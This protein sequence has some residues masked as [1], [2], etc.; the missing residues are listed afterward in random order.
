MRTKIPAKKSAATTA[1]SEA[2]KASASAKPVKAG[3][4]DP[5]SNANNERLRELVDALSI[6]QE[7][8][9]KRFNV[10]YGV[11]PLS[12]A[13]WKAYFVQPGLTRHRRFGALQLAHAE[14]RLAAPTSAPAKKRKTK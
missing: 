9:L 8:A 4:I 2:A 6:S 13:A 3:H 14:K 1:A 5:E 12:I 10:G 7:E 11:K